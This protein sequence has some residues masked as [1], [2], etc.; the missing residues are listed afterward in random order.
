MDTFRFLV[1]V[2]PCTAERKSHGFSFMGSA[3]GK[4]PCLQSDRNVEIYAEVFV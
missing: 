3:W 2:P 4:H 1:E